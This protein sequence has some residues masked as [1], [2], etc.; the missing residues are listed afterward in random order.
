MEVRFSDSDV[1][2]VRDQDLLDAI[3]KKDRCWMQPFYYSSSRVKQIQS[4]QDANEPDTFVTFS[5][6]SR[7]TMYFYLNPEI[8]LGIN[9][10][11]DTSI[12]FNFFYSNEDAVKDTYSYVMW[13]AG[14]EEEYF[15]YST[16]WTYEF[17]YDVVR[18]LDEFSKTIGELY[19]A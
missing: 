12:F 18:A 15:Q 13:N 9:Y 4:L 14:S 10:G 8:S 6:R 11:S 7:P 5:Y 1:F 3:Q 16:I 2:H 17:S 19:N